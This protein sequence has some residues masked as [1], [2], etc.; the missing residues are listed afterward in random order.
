VAETDDEKLPPT[1][2][3]VLAVFAKELEAKGF[4]EDRITVLLAVALE[5]EIRDTGL[6]VFDV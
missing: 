3:D 2:A 5:R 1:S 6:T 4:S